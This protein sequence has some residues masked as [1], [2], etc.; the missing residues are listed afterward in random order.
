VVSD[1]PGEETESVLARHCATHLATY[2]RPRRFVFVDA[3]PR[4]TYGKV[5]KRDLR[6]RFS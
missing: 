1:A 5:L 4:N 2:K 3:L 6:E